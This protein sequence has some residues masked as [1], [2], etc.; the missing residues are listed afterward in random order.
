MTT[1]FQC[2]TAHQQQPQIQCS[3]FKIY[4]K[5]QAN[6]QTHNKIAYRIHTQ[7]KTYTSKSEVI[8]KQSKMRC[9][10]FWYV[11]KHLSAVSHSVALYTII[12]CDGYVGVYILLFFSQFI[13]DWK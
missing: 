5:K 12:S 1:I 10:S 4:K 3:C 2:C 11:H 7:A 9:L 6:F 8:E 13:D